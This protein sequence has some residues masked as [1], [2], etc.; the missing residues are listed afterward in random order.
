MK[1]NYEQAD[2]ASGV[3]ASITKLYLHELA[4]SKHV[5]KDILVSRVITATPM[6]LAL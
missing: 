1:L 3:E 6:H 2:V 4:I 5:K